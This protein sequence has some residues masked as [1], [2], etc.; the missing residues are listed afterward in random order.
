MGF[1]DE[2]DRLSPQVRAT[3]L[4]GLYLKSWATMEWSLNHAIEDAL[5]L[6]SLEGAIVTKNIQ[7]RDKI[8][9]LRTLVDIRIVD[10][11]R[12]TAIKKRLDT[13]ANLA[14]D[15]NMVAHDMFTASE[16]GRGVSFFV[17][18][19]KGTLNFPETE[20][21]MQTFIQK[22]CE[23]HVHSD[24]LDRLKEEI[25]P[26][27]LFDQ[28]KALKESSQSGEPTILDSLYRPPQEPHDSG[29]LQANPQT[30]NEMPPKAEA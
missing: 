11:D 21:S 15:R 24:E 2:L 29:N 5:H 22:A 10:H 26:M 14:A 19:A 6:A 28:L 20:W 16:D 13:I 8:Y 12:R 9:I 25:P 4:V 23:L 30:D 1:H 27:T 7:F 3:A 18:R 17:T